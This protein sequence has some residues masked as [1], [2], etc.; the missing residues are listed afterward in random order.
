M[1][2]ETFT[3]V[4]PQGSQ[5]VLR[6]AWY[7]NVGQM[8]GR[9]MPDIQLQ[10]D[11]V[12]LQDGA[13]FRL[14]LHNER[15]FQLPLIIKDTSLAGLRTQL[16]ALTYA[17]DPTRGDGTLVINSVLG[18]TRQVVCRYVT[19]LQMQERSDYGRFSAQGLVQFRAYD[20]FWQD[21]TDTSQSW[22]LTSV[23]SF[24]PFFPLRLTSSELVVQDSINNTGDVQTWPVWTIT[25][26]GGGSDGIIL[27]NTTTDDEFTFMT[28]Q[29]LTGQS[30]TVDT[31][32]GV[33]TVTLQ[34]GTNLFGDLDP[35]SVLWPIV[36]GNNGI[37]LEMANAVPGTSALSVN[38]RRKYLSA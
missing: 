24:F 4:D 9:F 2:S 35:T 15:N 31:R 17:M 28:T 16:R 27:T 25:G 37:T 36:K 32:P 22:S 29:L 20:P 10:E 3:W 12:P 8:Q 38:Y 21:S 33:K 18:D 19:G 14:A 5:T 23:P 30:I 6:V 7:S 13:R 1:S 26:P 34:D 11:A